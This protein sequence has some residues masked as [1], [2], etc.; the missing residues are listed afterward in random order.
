MLIHFYFRT[1]IPAD[2][3]G[4]PENIYGDSDSNADN[5]CYDTEDYKAPKGLQNI[6]PCQYSK[7][8]HNPFR[9]PLKY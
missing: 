3:Y 5:A 9:M 1:G 7:S 2:F 4:T 6:S 8:S